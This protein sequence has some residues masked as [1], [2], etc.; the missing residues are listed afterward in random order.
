VQSLGTNS[1]LAISQVSAIQSSPQG[2]S[3]VVES[4]QQKFPAASKSLL[5][6]K[7][8]EISDFVDNRWQV[9]DTFSAWRGRGYPRACIIPSIWK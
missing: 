5:R 4:L 1:S 3:K 7:V 6:S 8:R 9:S 2:I